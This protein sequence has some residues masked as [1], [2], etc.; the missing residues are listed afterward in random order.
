M[1]ESRARRIPTRVGE[2]AVEQ[3]GEGTP[4]LLWPS[5]LADRSMWRHQAD[6]LA[7]DYRLLLV[8][9]PGH[10]ESA[11]PRGSFS[12]EDC[13]AAGCEVLDAHGVA[14]AVWVGLSWG[15]MTALRAALLAPGRVRALA[16]FDTSADAEPLAHRLRYQAMVTLYRRFGYLG[17]LA[18]PLA[19]ALFG[20][21]TLK[22]NPEVVETVF[23]HIRRAEPEGIALAAEAVIL[24][25]RPIRDQLG[26]LRIPTLVVVGEEDQAT[27]PPHAEA[28][29]AA[30]PGA[31]LERIAE[32]GHLSALEAPRQVNR[33]LRSFL[34]EL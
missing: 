20:A 19:R 2:L 34:A 16:L 30:I 11:V 15:G 33:I 26:R 31:R 22:T 17:L 10:G 4:L 14:A 5:L 23:A 9:G 3:R 18:R 6:E 7:G 24:N 21:T 12:L 29:A 13:A 8:D 25:R 27:P 28:I 32:C 1:K